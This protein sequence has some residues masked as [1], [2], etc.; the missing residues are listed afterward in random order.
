MGS[1]TSRPKIQRA[2]QIIYTSAPVTTVS[3]TA[4]ASDNTSSTDTSTSDQTS[5]AA[6]AVEDAQSASEN[7]ASNLL[8]R[9][10]GR[11]GTVLTSFRGVLSDFAGGGE[12][13]TLLGE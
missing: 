4:T 12:R 7:R 9:T 5:D 8:L 11:Q 10:R 1:L 6:S 13:K 2:P 3:S